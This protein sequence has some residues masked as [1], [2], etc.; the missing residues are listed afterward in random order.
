MI[1]QLGKHDQLISPF[2]AAKQWDLSNVDP[3]ELV[4]TETTG[5]EESVALEFMDYTDGVPFV[6]RSCNIALEQQAGDL[7][8]PE[9]GVS[10]SGTFFPD[11]EEKNQKTNSFKRLIYDQIQKAFYNDYKNPLQ[12]FGIE[13]IDFPLSQTDRFL[14]NEFL[15]FSIPRNVFGDRLTENTIQMFDTTFDDNLLIQDDGAGNL[16]AGYNLFSKVQEIR[17]F[18]NVISSGSVSLC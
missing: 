2:V 13:N 1:K 6:N 17:S 16:V 12:I 8:I 15:M 5:S 7:A 14:G 3:Q 18:G 9:A 4:L 11:V 10:G